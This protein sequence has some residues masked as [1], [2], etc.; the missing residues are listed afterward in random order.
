[1]LKKAVVS[2]QRM[3]EPRLRWVSSSSEHFRIF[4]ERSSLRKFRL[5]LTFRRAAALAASRRT[6]PSAAGARNWASAARES[7]A[8]WRTRLRASASARAACL[9]ALWASTDRDGNAIT[10]CSSSRRALSRICKPTKTHSAK[11]SSATGTGQYLFD[12]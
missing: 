7:R 5:A 9:A 1:M 2:R 8:A 10:A 11:T 12:W 3:S 6:A 4:R